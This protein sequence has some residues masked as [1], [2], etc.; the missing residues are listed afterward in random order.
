[1]I[2]IIF[3]LAYGCLWLRA[4]PTSNVLLE[5]LFHESAAR[6]RERKLE[7]RTCDRV[8]IDWRS[9]VGKK[10]VWL[11]TIRC[12][13]G[14]CLLES[15]APKFSLWFMILLC[16][17][18]DLSCFTTTISFRGRWMNCAV[19]HDTLDTF[20]RNKGRHMSELGSLLHWIASWGET[21]THGIV[22]CQSLGLLY[23]GFLKWG[24]ASHHPF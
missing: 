23:G 14:N 24:Y 6:R 15:S 13:Q 4:K 22:E 20:A 1:M 11:D 19:V 21:T 10:E 7:Q 8:H 9:S 18:Q 17:G 2:G 16:Q 5:Q 12:L 3:L